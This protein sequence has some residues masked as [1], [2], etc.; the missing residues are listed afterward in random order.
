MG[1]C[2]YLPATFKKRVI[3]HRPERASD[4]QGGFSETWT[5]TAAVSCSLEP[6]K[7]YER[8]QAMQLATPISHKLVMRFNP[9]V[10]TDTRLVLGTR[11][12]AVKEAL[13][14]HED[15]RYL[16]VRTVELR[17]VPYLP[18][19]PSDGSVLLEGGGY[20]LLED[21]SRLLLETAPGSGRFALEGGG[22]LSLE[23]GGNLQLEA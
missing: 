18:N 11:V 5:P 6:V 19:T 12:F 14:R 7:G 21:G 15:R 9:A 13:D 4:G 17:A 8:F 2:A 10:T 23:T 1:K 16:D 22:T 20:L 3:V